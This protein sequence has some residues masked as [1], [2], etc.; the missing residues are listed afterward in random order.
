MRQRALPRR[1]AAWIAAS[2]VMAGCSADPDR[3]AEAS[4]STA[5]P[6]VVQTPRP[7][8]TLLPVPAIGRLERAEASSLG[9]RS[10]GGVAR[11]DVGLGGV[12]GPGR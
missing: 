8:S 6:V 3:R 7:A 4:A 1:L 5:V 2:L 9:F 11:G 12:V 10:G